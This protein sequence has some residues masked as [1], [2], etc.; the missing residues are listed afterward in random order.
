MQEYYQLWAERSQKSPLAVRQTRVEPRRDFYTR[1]TRV[2]TRRDFYTRISR[3]AHTN[4]HCTRFTYSRREVITTI[5]FSFSSNN[6]IVD[7]QI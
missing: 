4:R 5:D 2:E 6:T 7:I 3:T 1:Q